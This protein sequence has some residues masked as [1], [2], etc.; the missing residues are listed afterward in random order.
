MSSRCSL[1]GLPGSS[2]SGTAVIEVMPSASAV[3]QSLNGL[4]P[5]SD[6]TT[7][8]SRSRYSAS[9]P[10]SS[11]RLLPTS[12]RGSVVSSQACES[13]DIATP[14]STRSMP[15][16]QVF[17]TKSTPY[18]W[19]WAES[20]PQRMLASRTQSAIAS[21]S[22]SLKPNRNRIGAASARLST[23]L[24]VARPPA[25]S[26]SCAATPSSGLVWVSA[27]SASLTLSRCAGWRTVD[28]VA[29]PEARDDQRGIGL[30]VRAH[31][32]DVARFEGGVVGEQPQQYLPQH[33]DLPGRAV[34]AVH[35]DRAVVGGQPPP[36][37]RT[38]LAAMSDCSQPSSV[39]GRS[40]DPR[41][42]SVCGSAG[43]LRCSSRRSR[44]SVA[45]SGCPTS[46]CD[47]SPRAGTVP[48]TPCSDP[49][50]SSL[51]CGS[52]RCRSW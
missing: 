51:G 50:R 34:A 35:L 2:E 47:V 43:R 18:G 19:R 37:R 38:A 36:S 33:V 26:S 5:E 31:D 23:S 48:C 42:S 20:K 21:R 13:S 29:E 10:A 15:N 16:R 4:V 12:S 11:T 22:S 41:H 24:A 44:P 28:D 6:S 25:R 40:A 39:S 9:R 49:H 7:P 52:H 8:C 17:C 27:R 32:E 46:R 14:A 1:A 3:S 45:S 30:D